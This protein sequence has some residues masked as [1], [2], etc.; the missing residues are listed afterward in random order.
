[1]LINLTYFYYFC[2]FLLISFLKLILRM[3]YIIVNEIIIKTTLISM[4]SFSKG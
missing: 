2:I 3:K 1:M 4:I